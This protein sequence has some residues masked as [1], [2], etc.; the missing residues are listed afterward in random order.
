MVQTETVT[1][2]QKPSAT[3]TEIAFDAATLVLFVAFV[4]FLYFG[5]I[6]LYRSVPFSALAAVALFVSLT[7]LF[8]SNLRA[9]RRPSEEAMELSS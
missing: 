6:G 9:A 4:A 5:Y 8:S 3:A 7:V 2:P 1:S